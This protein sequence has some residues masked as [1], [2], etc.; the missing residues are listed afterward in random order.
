MKQTDV[1]MAEKDWVERFNEKFFDIGFENHYYSIKEFISEA[2][3][4]RAD[5]ARREGY[6]QGRRSVMDELKDCSS[7]SK[8]C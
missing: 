8:E 3:A 1:E 2:L 7:V 5:E 4:T 6:E